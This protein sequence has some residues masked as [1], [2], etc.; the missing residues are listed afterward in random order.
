MVPALPGPE[1]GSQVGSAVGIKA[2]NNPGGVRQD[3]AVDPR[4]SLHLRKQQPKAEAAAKARVIKRERQRAKKIEQDIDPSN[5]KMGQVH[6][7]YMRTSQ[8]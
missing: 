3:K 2:D 7:G 8:K 4:S 1:A 5:L 6:L